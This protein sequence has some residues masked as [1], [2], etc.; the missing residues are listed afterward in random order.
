MYEYR[1]TVL[2]LVDGD[3]LDALVDLG[4]GIFHKIRVRILHI[5]APEEGKLG[6]H[7][8][9]QE[10]KNILSSSQ[11]KVILKSQKKDSFGRWLS[12]LYL[13]STKESISDLLL[14]AKVVEPYK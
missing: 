9:I 7:M 1:A 10:L 6:Y 11:W 12:D 3:T 2:S 14:S 8:A 5:N 4:F 13:E